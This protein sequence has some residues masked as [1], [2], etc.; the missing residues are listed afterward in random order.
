[1]ME[2]VTSTIKSVS[3]MMAGLAGRPIQP[4]CSFESDSETKG[5]TEVHVMRLTGH[6]TIAGVATT[7]E[8]GVYSG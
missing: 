6:R 2:E 1:M 4:R 5:L 3:L 7:I 8:K